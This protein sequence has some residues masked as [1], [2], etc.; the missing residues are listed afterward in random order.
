[1]IK[2]PRHH[3]RLLIV[4]IVLLWLLPAYLGNTGLWSRTS[5]ASA[6]PENAANLSDRALT[7]ESRRAVSAAYGKLPLSFEANEGQADSAVRF[8]SRA[9]GS[10]VFLTSD[11][12]VV[13]LPVSSQRSKRAANERPPLAKANAI[14]M[15]L[16]GADPAVE[17]VGS[18]QL[19][20]K[21]NYFDGQAAD[22]WRS[23]IPTYARVEYRQL[24]PQV[25]L[26][27]YGNQRQLEYDFQVNPGGDPGAIK[28]NFAGV[29]KISLSR[30]GD[31]I[32]RAASSDL[33]LHKPFVY[34][35]VGGTRQ[36]VAGRYVLKGRRQVGFQVGRY[37]K[38]L[39]L[40]IDPVLSYSTFLGGSNNEEG[41]GIALDAEGNAYVTGYTYSFNFPVSINGYN[42]TYASAA[43]VFV[44]KLNADGSALVYS[45][46][47][48]GSSDDKATGIALDSG[49]SVYVTG[50]TTSANFPTTPGAFQTTWHGT[51][52][53]SSNAFVSKLSSNGAVLSYS[54][55]L[56]GS[57]SINSYA[58]DQANGIDVD[59]A[60]NAYVAGGAYSADFPTTPGA[61]KTSPPTAGTQDGFVTEVN[62]TGTAL[63]YS[64][65]LGGTHDDQAKA[66]K[67][68][69]AGEA[70]VTG[71]TAST[72]FPTTPGAYQT[73]Y[74]GPAEQYAQFGD[75]FVA[76]LNMAGSALVYST[77]VGG[78]WD[79]TANGLA[80]GPAGEVYLTGQT[81]SANFPTTAGVVG[82]ANG[83]V[84]RLAQGAGSWAN[85]S[86]GLGHNS[87]SAVVINP[88]DPSVL[89]AA[90]GDGLFKSTD[91][92]AHWTLLV[93]A[94]LTNF[95]H[96]AIDPVTPSTVYAGAY[97]YGVY[98]TTNAGVTWTAINSGLDDT[99]I[100]A[101]ELDPSNPQTIYASNGYGVSKST[102]G[103]GSWTKVKAGQ[104]GPVRV[105][106]GNGAVVYAGENH[107]LY[108]STNGGGNWY[109]TGLYTSPSAIAVD[110][111]NAA[112]VYVSSSGGV[113][114]STDGGSTW[115]TK[116]NGLASLSVGALALAPDNSS[117]IYAGTNQGVFKTTDAGATWNVCGSGLAGVGVTR[118]AIDPLDTQTIYAAC[119]GATLDAFVTELNAAGT[120]LIY[121]TYLGGVN[122]E[123]GNAIAVDADGNAYVTGY[124]HSPNF[125]T[126]RGTYGASADY[127]YSK[128][129]ISKF[130]PGATGLVYSTQIGGYYDVG[131]GVAVD[132]SNRA[133]LVGTT[134][135]SN[136]PTT[137]GVFQPSLSG[138]S[139]A[140]ITRLVAE[141]TL[142]SDLS[143]DLT[144][145]PF[146]SPPYTAGAPIQFRV[147]V[148]NNGPDPAYAVVAHVELSPSL[149]FESCTSDSTAQ[150]N[151][152]GTGIIGT[153]NI[154]AVGETIRFVFGATVSCSND[155]TL[156]ISST[157]TVD[158]A[159]FDSPVA[160]NAATK[161][162]A[163]SNPQT[164]LSPPGQTFP[165]SGGSASVHVTRGSNC[166]WQAQSNADW[167]TITASDGCC[168]GSV[169]YSVAANNGVSRSGT[170]TIAGVTFTVSQGGTDCGQSLTPTS[171]LFG[172]SPGNGSITVT[173]PG[174]CSWVAQ[175]NS[176][177]ITIT[178]GAGTQNGTVSYSVAAN[179]DT[180]ARTG[181][182]S[183]GDQVFSVT[184]AG[185]PAV[186]L[187][188][189]K[190]DFDGD[191]KTDMGYYRNGLWGFLKSGQSFSPGSSR[192]FSWGG[193][194]LQPIC[195]DFDGDGLADIAY[196]VPPS[197]G[198]SATY[199]ILLSSRNYSFAAGQPLFVPAGYPSLGDI[200]M[201]A[202]F[203]GDGLAD[204][205]IWRA[206]Q[207]IWII[208]KSSTNYTTYIFAQ[209]GQLG[210]VP[211][212][213][214]F[215][216][217][218]K[219]DIGYYHEGLW[220]ILKSSRNYSTSSLIFY[221][222]GGA[223]LQPVCADFDGDGVADFGYLVPPSGGQSATYSILLSS[224]N[225]SFAAGQPLFVPAGYPSL[226]DTPV[227][228]DFD[229]DGKADPGIW[230]ESQ[231]VWIVPKSSM[232]Y[233][234]YIFSQ[235]GEPGDIAFPNTT[236]KH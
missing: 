29:R 151:I 164:T 182:I 44:T 139:D 134:K 102:N 16:A 24:Y 160:N 133:H 86:D 68:A 123:T 220:A 101:L 17:I 208:P 104:G 214:D 99:A 18:D 198:Q 63:V 154:L 3:R 26:V 70:V 11:G 132:A 34:Q 113:Y 206:S 221:N 112:I 226:G 163:V 124:S 13:M 159:S 216:H 72:D 120:G 188:Y 117:V 152:G 183:V 7:E 169:S 9:G 194:G 157:A 109:L 148:T 181:S 231:G 43:D 171:Q 161:T 19:P 82:V 127:T 51:Y 222:W 217:D 145:Q 149:S 95:F 78:N 45:T 32:L 236:G 59:A 98:K 192:F 173:S 83:G 62:S 64:T 60:G 5:V 28:M 219:A 167:I 94:P 189:I 90:G 66:V 36:A 146:G 172:P 187:S 55:Y 75:A 190:M 111:V 212:A 27:Y 199:S 92:G 210:D 10:T 77:Y 6:A 100:N 56:G 207:G 108:K 69:S 140:F 35:E 233:T 205:G 178:S 180:N 209:W 184:Q 97:G 204:P 116:N 195:A 54:T 211:V 84:A 135:N 141:P 136:F 89:Y 103:G 37:D 15:R 30:D 191:A 228:G 201:V 39:P 12:A 234:A 193:S 31:L 156:T 106:P 96:L 73:T 49:G 85:R 179:P 110:P 74:A 130:N 175:S 93:G 105:A 46:Y 202:D 155:N 20:G 150:C 232:N 168:D 126:T 166:T 107:A 153:R 79:D 52:Y 71:S 223:G 53:F 174:G 142:S 225:Y 67:V 58:G 229:G 48:G 76:R 21:T 218:G 224:R 137:A 119:G 33:R 147:T 170:M 227:V 213:A 230:R 215:D 80:L 114:K 57:G 129:F 131:Y 158:S 115:Q 186:G 196:L 165:A 87:P 177:W 14:K 25:N 50:W 203:D 91:S 22:R 88:L 162:L 40:V 125:P 47:L 8:I 1:M 41:R 185:L 65:Y 38:T 128:V 118:L 122:A 23:N 144:M 176:S 4:T 61:L 81:N 138:A 235:W 197:G 200:P 121:S 2:L 143:L 42:S